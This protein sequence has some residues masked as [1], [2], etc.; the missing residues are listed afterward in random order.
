MKGTEDAPRPQEPA[1]AKCLCIDIETARQDRT[2]LREL[3]VFRPDTD[4][5]LRLSGKVYIRQKSIGSMMFS[6]TEIIGSN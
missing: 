5:R 4:V 6:M 1:R 3:G 2:R